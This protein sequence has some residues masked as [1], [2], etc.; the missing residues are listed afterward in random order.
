[1]PVIHL[2]TII[3]APIERCFD[4]SRSIDLHQVSTA[5]TNEMPVAGVTKGLIKQGEWVTWRARHFGIYQH[6]TVKIIK[7]NS[8]DSFEDEMMKGAFKQMKHLHFFEQK[9]QHTIMRDVFEFES[10]FGVLGKLFNKL[11][12]TNYMKGFLIERNEAIKAIAEGEEWRR[13]LYPSE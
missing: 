5:K 8:P 2:S 7:M 9:G 12:L 11:V 4:L 13:Y 10:P 3:N 6:L 1:M